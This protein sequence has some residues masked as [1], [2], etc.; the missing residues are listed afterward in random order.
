MKLCSLALDV[1]PHTGK[2]VK[3]RL[4]FLWKKR[5]FSKKWCITLC[6]Y[7]IS[8]SSEIKLQSWNLREL[9]TP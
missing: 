9:L 3:N 4:K 1:A 8:Q 5:K 6:I 2:I 7:R